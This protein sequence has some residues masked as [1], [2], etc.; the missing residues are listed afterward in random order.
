M[1]GALRAVVAGDTGG[2]AHAQLL[3]WADMVQGRGACAMPDGAARLVRSTLS[4]FAAD[5]Q[6]HRDRGPCPAASPLL[7]T[8]ATGGWR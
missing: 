7:P 3:R 4:V 6:A 1:A 8:P 2:P 5:V